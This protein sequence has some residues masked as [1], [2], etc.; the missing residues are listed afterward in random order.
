MIITKHIS[1]LY[2]S[3]R[4]MPSYCCVPQYFHQKKYIHTFAPFTVSALRR[5]TLIL[6]LTFVSLTGNTENS[7][8]L[9]FGSDV[10]IY[11]KENILF[12]KS[13]TASSYLEDDSFT[14]QGTDLQNN[15][16]KQQCVLTNSKAKSESTH[17]SVK[18]K[19][20]ISMQN[21]KHIS[22]FTD[23]VHLCLLQTDNH[24]IR[25]SLYNNLCMTNASDI[26]NCYYNNKSTIT[27]VVPIYTIAMRGFLNSFGSRLPST[28]QL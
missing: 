8:I 26:V 12:A 23:V 21:Y 13:K 9:Y 10:K 14:T 16:Q 19:G 25:K 7:A 18:A 2:D 6:L 27:D 28:D 5:G 11:D 17:T 15:K 24:K 4:K 1:H 20:K 22:V 3:V